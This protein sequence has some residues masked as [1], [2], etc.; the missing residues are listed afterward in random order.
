MDIDTWMSEHVPPERIGDFCWI[1]DNVRALDPDSDDETVCSLRNDL[2][3]IALVKSLQELPGTYEVVF[4][5]D[6]ERK[7]QLVAY[8]EKLER[9]KELTRAHNVHF[10]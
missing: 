10:G 2:K 1:A 3:Q 6:P 7:R 9:W 8:L 4:R 5:E